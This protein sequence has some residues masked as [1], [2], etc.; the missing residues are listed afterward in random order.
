MIAA[1]APYGVER[2]CCLSDATGAH[3]GT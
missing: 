1:S 3:S 2:V